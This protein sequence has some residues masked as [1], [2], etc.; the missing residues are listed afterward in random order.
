MTTTRL[1]PTKLVLAVIFLLSGSAVLAQTTVST[2]SIAG[3]VTDPTGAVISDARITV[4][5]AGTGQATML[6]TNA[7]GSYNSGALPPGTYKVQVTASGF[8]T[9]IQTITVQVGNTAAVNFKL[10]VGQGTTTVEVQGSTVQVNT[11][12]PEVQ[13]VLTSQ[14]IDNLPVN[15]RNFLDLAQLEPG[16]QI[17]DGQN[18]D[19]TKAGYSSIS[20]GGRFGRTA[21]INVDGVDV[22]DETVGTTTEDIPSSAIQEFQLA[23]SSLDLSTDLTSS[24]AVNVTTK[25]GTN[26]LHGQGFGL[27]RDASVGGA[28][29]PGG[30]NL[31]F[32]RSQFGGNLGGAA[33]KDKLFLFGDA[34]RIKQD[35][36]APVLFTN[37]F[38]SFNG[39]F[40][41]PFR[42]TEVLGRVDYNVGNSGKAFYRFS[43][44]ANSL[45]SDF[46]LGYAVYDNKDYTRQHVGGYDFVTGNFSHSIRFSYLKFQNQIVDLVKGSNLPL[47]DLNV[48]LASNGTGFYSGPSP[49]APQSTPQANTEIKY[50]GSKLYKAHLF[51]YGVMWNHIQGG[52]FANFYGTAPR[53]RWLTNASTEAFAA[54][55]GN[56]GASN[57]LNYPVNDVRV[58]NGLGFST[59]DPALGFPAGGLG[60]DNRIGIY[61][62]DVWKFSSNSTITLGLRYDRDTGRTD[63]DLGAIPEVNAA[64]PGWGNPVRQPNTNF[65]PQMGFAWDP[66]KDGKTS[67]R[68]GIGLYF[69]NVIYNNVLFD[70]PLRLTTGAFNQTPFVC[71]GGTALPAQTNAGPITP[72]PGV[73]ANADGSKITVGQ[74]IPN[75]LAFQQQVLAG[76]PLDL[77]APNPNYIGNDLA[78]GLG[79][80]LGFFAPNY[81]TPRSVQI[82]I[83]GQ[84]QLR[85]GMVLSVDYLRNVE[86]HSLLGIDENHVG[87]V[88]NFNLANAQAAIAATNA[89][90]KCPDVACAIQNGAQMTDYAG[91]G[92][93]ADSDFG[94][95]CDQAIG[96]NCAFPGINNTQAA[97]TFL[98]PI[99]RSSYD[100]MQVKLVQNM[101]RLNFQFAYSL[102]RLENS[103]GA[104]ATGTAGDNDQDFVTASPDNNVPNRY[105]G[106]TLLDRTNQ[107]SLGGF[108]DL[109]LHFNLGIIGHFY[110]PLSSPIVVPNNGLG[111]GEIFRSDFTGDGTVQDP[112]PGTHMGN[113]DRGISASQLTNTINNYNS[114]YGNLP[115]PAGQVLV[116]QGL[117]TPA[118]LQ[119]LN[120]V[121][122][123]LS[124]PP[125]GE[126][127]FT[128]L[129]SFD[130]NLGWKYTIKER[131]TIQPSVAF[132]NLFNFGNFN[133]PP[134]TMSGILY[135]APGAINGT[136]SVANETFRVGNG[137]GVYAV[138]AA[139]QTEWG[140]KFSF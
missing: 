19:P 53:I 67:I 103:G 8:N 89:S 2:G 64:F 41:V 21:R 38:T 122:P 134:N 17:Q 28:S 137:T 50:D 111:P 23:Q 73:C 104:Q 36:F 20:F 81:R 18:F 93:T 31:P 35:S 131:F 15:G 33:I 77:K 65:S 59:L 42:E 9:V 34:E 74:A 123:T 56:G 76:N 118:Q 91:N 109:P 99:G 116:Q 117:M 62:G 126:V 94:Q 10:E 47:A 25:S 75:V 72:G 130:L 69:E 90:F 86:T 63:S 102:S 6:N 133:L 83:G 29:S 78:A 26:T 48:T 124:A 87:D 13:G 70:R 16:V 37:P 32:Q 54:A 30:T 43:Y 60:P 121:A 114:K 57:P 27:F 24:G 112:M 101:K 98:E 127:N 39:G 12:Q 79:I 95:A 140:L 92:L 108:G 51:R 14:Q 106:Q 88:K 40:S 84:R 82:N 115:T 68:G 45:H 138:G 3:S 97:A 49:L 66:F 22:S 107:F 46:G 105:Y 61:F 1:L 139:R 135:G 4:T 125:P 7:A 113:F 100:A 132:F 96:V 11:E 136:D 110:S 58:G 5:N 44:F 128:W 71:S 129:R 80:P 85:Q 120:G 119:A 55:Q 52:G